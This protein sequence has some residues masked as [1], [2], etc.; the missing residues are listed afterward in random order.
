MI[1]AIALMIGAYI[2]TRML[3]KILDDDSKSIVRIFGALTILITLYSLYSVFS[4]GVDI[5][6][7][8]F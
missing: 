6:N 7:L 2:I 8:N 3:E 5:S 4:A 1:P